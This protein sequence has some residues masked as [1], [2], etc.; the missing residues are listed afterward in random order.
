MAT[1]LGQYCLL[2]HVFSHAWDKCSIYILIQTYEWIYI[3]SIA[4]YMSIKDALLRPVFWHV[5]DKCGIYIL[6][7]TYEWIYIQ[8]IL[9]RVFALRL[10]VAKDSSFLLAESEA[11]VFAGPTCHFVGFVM[12]WLT[13]YSAQT[14][15]FLEANF[16]LSNQIKQMHV[17]LSPITLSTYTLKSPLHT[18]Q[19]FWALVWATRPL[20]VA[21]QTRCSRIHW[22]KVIAQ[23]WWCCH[24]KFPC[25]S[26]TD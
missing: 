17:T 2:R 10:M 5:W 23:M 6:I 22:Y 8:P 21:Q 18:V 11:W 26:E 9:I 3:L 1:D 7:Q 20:L 25:F 16:E 13:W 14:L 12:R 4:A 24:V 15:V 19:L